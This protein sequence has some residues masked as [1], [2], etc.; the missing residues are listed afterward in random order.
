MSTNLSQLPLDCKCVRGVPVDNGV[1]PG[2]LG[3]RS[4]LGRR[5]T[6]V[7]VAML[8]HSKLD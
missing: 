4:L 1:W 8:F 5:Y 2:R 6:S 3:R 7:D